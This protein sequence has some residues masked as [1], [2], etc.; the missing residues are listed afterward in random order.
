MKLKTI[1]LA[2]AVALAAFS[3]AS[4][5]VAPGACAGSTFDIDIY[6]TGASAVQNSLAGIVA[7]IMNPGFTVVFDNGT[8][9]TKGSAYR[10][11]CG[12]LNASTGA[13]SGKKIRLLNRA[14]GG[15]VF[16]VNP[17]ARDQAIATLNFADA[18]CA[19]SAI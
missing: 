12:T 7:E 13:L 14:R 3:S 4:W 19:A 9:G 17:V 5:A 2:G 16:G 1:H 18:T 15:S 8:S 10:A 11:Y 6:L